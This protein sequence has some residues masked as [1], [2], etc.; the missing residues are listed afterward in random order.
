[1]TRSGAFNFSEIKPF[2]TVTIKKDM[3]LIDSMDI[4]QT[5]KIFRAVSSVLGRIKAPWYPMVE[6]TAKSIT[7]DPNTLTIPKASGVYIRVT[8]GVSK[9]PTICEMI[10]TDVRVS[11]S[12]VNDLFLLFKS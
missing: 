11:T 6:K 1:M 8:M 3:V 9:M 10:G 4:K 12:W 7:T 2:P 5:N